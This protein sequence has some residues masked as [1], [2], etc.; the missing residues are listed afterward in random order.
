MIV[1]AIIDH[2]YI[3]LIDY[4]R[5]WLRYSPDADEIIPMHKFHNRYEWLA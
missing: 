3:D 5:S 2:L 1:I 4:K